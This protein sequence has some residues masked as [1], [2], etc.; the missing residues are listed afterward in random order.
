MTAAVDKIAQCRVFC[1]RVAET[2][3]MQSPALTPTESN[4]ARLLQEA[5]LEIRQQLEGVEAELYCTKSSPSVVNA[6]E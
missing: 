4:L 3:A 5:M 1:E 6:A 2:A